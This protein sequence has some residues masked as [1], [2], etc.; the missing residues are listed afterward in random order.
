MSFNNIK[1]K[2]QG[3]TIVELLIVVVVI[4]ILAAITIVSYNGITAR[5]NTSAAQSL[6][7]NIVKKAELYAS[8]DSTTS[9]PLQG[10]DLTNSANSSKAYYIAST[11][12]NFTTGPTV[13]PTSSNGKNTVRFLK[14]A[15]SAQTSQA[16]ITASN[17]T[18]I[19]ITYYD[20]SASNTKDVD[21]GVTTSCPAAA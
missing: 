16:A 9:Y 7:A 10:S 6:A 14:C 4:A 13:L 15:S 1:T 19:R 12:V 2:A 20:F 11:S 5:A 21:T 18:G 3:F 17:I 8:D